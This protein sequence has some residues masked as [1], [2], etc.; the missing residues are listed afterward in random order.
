MR[1]FGCLAYAHIR[2]AVRSKLEP[3]ARP[4]VFVGYTADAS[5]Y[6]LWDPLNDKL[7]DSRDVYFVESQ[8]GIKAGGASSTPASSA[9]PP[10]PLL[11]RLPSSVLNE[12]LNEGPYSPSAGRRASVSVPAASE[13]IAEPPAAPPA[14]PAAPPAQP[15]APSEPRPRQ[16]RALRQLMDRNVPGP[17]DHA[18]STLAQLALLAHSKAPVSSTA[19]VSDDPATY[20][21]A[22]ASPQQQQWRAAM[23]S[24]MKSLDKAGTYTLVPLPPGRSAIGCKWVFKTKRGADGSVTKHKARLVA[25]GFLQRYGVDYEETYAPVARYSSIRALLALTAHHDWELHQMDVK[26]A[27]LNGDLEEDIYMTQPEGYQAPGR[28]QLVCKLS[29]SLYGLKQAGRTW[30]TKID[31]ALK[32][33]GFAS[34][35]ADECVYLKRHGAHTT[36][37]ALY[38]D[39]LLIACS[40]A[41]ELSQLKLDLTAQFD[42]E[43][44]GEAAFILGIDIRRDR[45]ARTL[46]IGQSAYVASILERHGMSNCTAVSTPMQHDHKI[47]LAKP[48]EGYQASERDIRDYQAV[49]GAVMFAMIC[50]RPDIAFAVN[51]LAQFAS[52]P[53]PFHQQAVK[54]VL[55]YLRGTIDR[56]ITY[57]GSTPA[58]LSPAFVGYCDADWGGG[59]GFR[60]VSGYAFLLAGG[61]ISWQSKRQKT[62]ALSTV[63]A[64]YMATTEAVKE[65]IWWRS[66]LADLGLDLARPTTVFSD[67]QGSIALAHNPEHHAQTKHIAI[68]YHF[69]R[70]YVA[71][72]TIDLTFIGTTDMAADLFTKALDRVAYERGAQQLGLTAC[73][74]RGGVEASRCAA[75]SG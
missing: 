61:A 24:E 16:P 47:A 67:S 19:S 11:P 71:S 15:A 32:R 51:T 10:L 35:D 38:V 3:K 63:E 25:K 55:Q 17:R 74:S 62:V 75:V 69:I 43:D 70:E 1:V 39:D 30:H 65:A 50:T 22:V 41:A 18:P 60:S 29:K 4:C 58:A 72:K 68:R 53:A 5:T 64:E 33:K 40:S 28:E 20:S 27:Y 14:Q 42:T 36:V 7:F 52:N 26:S 59:A 37:I 45:A 44:L 21:A 56:R 31:V 13:P 49:I 48:P 46:S 54:R 2:K 66:F 6:R 73:S 8:L 12:P 23:D 34:L 9:S 57:T